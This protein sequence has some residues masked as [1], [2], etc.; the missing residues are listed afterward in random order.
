VS[1]LIVRTDRDGVARLELHRPDVRNALSTALLQQLRDQL[2]A[3]RDD[4]TPRVLVLT[5]AGEA[6][7]AGADVKEFPAGASA[8]QG[9]VRIRL[10]AEVIRRLSELEVPTLAAVH[11][12]AVGAGWGLALACDVCFA[13]RDARFALPEVAKGFRL[14]APLVDRLVQVVGPVRAAD[15]V[16]G[17][18]TY[19]AADAL[20]GGWVT[21]VLD[22][23]AELAAQ[24]DQ[25]TCALAASPRRSVATAIG[26]LRRSL[27]TGPFP[28]PE[29][30]WTEES[31]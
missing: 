26:P 15:I 28:P 7:S 17:G 6:F 10:V 8:Q 23:P 11:G 29:L 2:A 24:A 31:Q 12:P 14:P 16:L 3:I 9:L 21:R 18:A 1:Q 22:T 13:T 30:I 4:P 20:A 19:S 27:P 5:G 25:L